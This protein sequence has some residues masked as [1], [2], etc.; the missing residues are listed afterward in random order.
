[1]SREECFA[2]TERIAE[3]CA[4]AGLDIVHPF[5]V[6]ACDWAA[7]KSAPRLER[8][9]PNAL[10]L[11]IGNTRELWARFLAKPPADVADPLDRYVTE[12]VALAV[13]QATTRFSQL[14]FAHTLDPAPFPIQRL[15]ELVG[16]ATLSPSHLAIHPIHGP[17][18]AL[19]AVVI[20]DVDGPAAR[21]SV[22][23]S[24]CATC[25]A[26]CVPALAHAIRV[27]GTP[28][29]ARAVAAHAREWIAVRDACPVGRASRYSDAQLDYHYAPS[30]SKLAQGS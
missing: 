5:N 12:K 2:I 22:L 21:P 10:G 15:A 30:A 26:P 24:P 18:F 20:V 17:W 27:S 3:A 7:L 28:L 6:A 1:V 23:A 29:G 16:L 9:R 4:A 19:R 25:S 8:A 13:D 11:V 14:F